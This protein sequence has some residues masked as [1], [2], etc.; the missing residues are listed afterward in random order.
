MGRGVYELKLIEGV[1]DSAIAAIEC[2][3]QVPKRALREGLKKGSVMNNQET[4]VD[5]IRINIGLSGKETI[6]IIYLDTQHR[7]IGDEVYVGTIDEVHIS[8]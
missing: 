7:L 6:Q 3:K 2:V 4:L 1:T 5:Y 8:P